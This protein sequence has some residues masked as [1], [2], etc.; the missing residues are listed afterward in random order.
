VVYSL[1]K[2]FFRA[3][4]DDWKRRSLV[5]V[6]AFFTAGKHLLSQPVFEIPLSPP[7]VGLPIPI[8]LCNHA[9]RL[10][11]SSP[12]NCVVCR[13]FHVVLHVVLQGNSTAGNS[14]VTGIL[15]SRV[16]GQPRLLA[17]SQLVSPVTTCSH[18]LAFP[19]CKEWASSVKTLWKLSRRRSRSN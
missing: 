12:S 5:S 19:Y 3:A 18:A 8:K 14:F 4:F 13:F 15:R 16:K 17:H 11:S 10:L 9:P 1:I 2:A 7:N 6:D